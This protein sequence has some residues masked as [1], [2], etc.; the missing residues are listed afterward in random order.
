MNDATIRPCLHCRQPLARN[1]ASYCGHPCRAAARSV[2]AAAERLPAPCK[3]CGVET[4]KARK[5]GAGVVCSDACLRESRR[6]TGKANAAAGKGPPVNEITPERREAARQRLTG[7]NAPWWKGGRSLTEAGY[8]MVAPPKNYPFP[9]S[10]GAAGRIREHRMVMELHLGR[11]LARTEVVHHING[12][13]SDNRIE[14]LELH[15][16]AAEHMAEHAETSAANILKNAKATRSI[17]AT[18]RTCGRA[19]RT[20]ARTT[21]ECTP[22]RSVRY[23]AAR[24]R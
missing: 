22:C 24:V 12:N 18:C 17:P 3:I 19:Y 13:R 1:Q 14:N 23:E 8:V 10:V 7:P 20:N 11:A 6:R 21:G 5:P 9:Q 2:A 16:S 15:A 4:G